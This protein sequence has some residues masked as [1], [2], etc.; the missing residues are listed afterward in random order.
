MKDAE[1]KSLAESRDKKKH[2]IDDNL[3][4]K[5]LNQK[6]V[7]SIYFSSINSWA[8]KNSCVESDFNCCEWKYFYN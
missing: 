4:L 1:I 2:P 7:N 5:P 6:T 8:D 3:Y